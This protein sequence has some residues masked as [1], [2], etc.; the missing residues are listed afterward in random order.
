M[1]H[2]RQNEGNSRKRFETSM[3]V[4]GAKTVTGSQNEGNS[5][6][7]FETCCPI[8]ADAG[9]VRVRTRVIRVSGL[10]L[11]P[12]IGYNFFRPIGQNEGNSRKRFE[13]LR[14]LTAYTNWHVVS[15]RG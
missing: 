11:S 6:K 5:R 3:M 7:R 13:T 8:P 1:A 14:R 4:F 15:E 10:K 12:G 9:G 2:N